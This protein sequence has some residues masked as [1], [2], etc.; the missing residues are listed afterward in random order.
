MHFIQIQLNRMALT[1]LSTIRLALYSCAAALAR[2]KFVFGHDA[3][4]SQFG[5]PEHK[6]RSRNHLPLVILNA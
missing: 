1:F 5:N 2:D 3:K 6:K 4:I